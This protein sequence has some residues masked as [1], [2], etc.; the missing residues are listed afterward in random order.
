MALSRSGRIIILLVLN[1]IMF[2]AE[3]VVGYMTG[4]L[5]LIA[6]AFHMLSDLLSQIIALYAIRVCIPWSFLS[7][8]C[9]LLSWCLPNA[10]MLHNNQLLTQLVRD[11]FFSFCYSWQQRQSGNQHCRTDGSEQS[12]WE[13][14]TTESSFSPFASPSSWM[15]SNGSSRPKVRRKQ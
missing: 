13:H 6:D 1:I 2:L 9:C 3:I 14:C 10:S 7:S 4:S 15:P 5:A 12:C 11:I 8:S